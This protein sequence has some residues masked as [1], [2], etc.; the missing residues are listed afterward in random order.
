MANASAEYS[1]KGILRELLTYKSGVFGMTLLALLVLISLY[2][3]ITIP[4]STAIELWRG[5]ENIWIENPRNAQPYWVRYF[6]K[7]LPETIKRDS[8]QA[9]R[10]GTIKVLTPILE[11]N[12]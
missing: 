6:G 1:V 7:N 3:V 11:R 9:G 4:Y 5:G 8:T 12:M 10:V 2:T